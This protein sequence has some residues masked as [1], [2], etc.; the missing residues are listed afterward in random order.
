MGKAHQNQKKPVQHKS[1]T[2][3]L[4]TR[5][6]KTPPIQCSI[7]TDLHLWHSAMGGSLQ[8]QHRNPPALPIQDSPIH[9]ERTL[10][11]KQP[12]NPWRPTNEHSAQRNKKVSAKYLTKLESNTN[13]LAVNLL[14]N[15]DNGKVDYG[16]Q[17]SPPLTL[18]L[19]QLISLHTPSLLSLRYL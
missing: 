8:F 7:Q 16:A 10:V 1:E 3:A 18:N 11:H 13:A 15:S 19:T 9:S 4:A 17:K 6:I 14:D 12:K 5:K 2:I